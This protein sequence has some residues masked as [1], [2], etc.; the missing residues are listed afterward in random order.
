MK[1]SDNLENYDIPKGFHLSV[2]QEEELARIVKEIIPELDKRKTSKVETRK[3]FKQHLRY[4]SNTKDDNVAKGKEGDRFEEGESYSPL[5]GEYTWDSR[6]LHPV[7]IQVLLPEEVKYGYICNLLHQDM[8]SRGEIEARFWTFISDAMVQFAQ[9]FDIEEVKKTARTITDVPERILYLNRVKADYDMYEHMSKEQMEWVY[10]PFGDKLD[11]LLKEARAAYG[12][13][14]D[15]NAKEKEDKIVAIVDTSKDELKLTPGS[16][17]YHEDVIIN[18]LISQFNVSHHRVTEKIDLETLEKVRSIF[19]NEFNCFLNDLSV[20]GRQ[21]TAELLSY[22]DRWEDDLKRCVDYAYYHCPEY[23]YDQFIEVNGE[24]RKESF[25][26]DNLLFAKMAVQELR[27][28]TYGFKANLL[29]NN[30]ETTEILYPVWN[31]GYKKV[32]KE[33]ERLEKSFGEIEHRLQLTDYSKNIELFY[34]KLIPYIKSVITESLQKGDFDDIKEMTADTCGRLENGLR[35]MLKEYI[36]LFSSRE[37]APMLPQF[38][39]K[40]WITITQYCVLDAFFGVERVIFSS[41]PLIQMCNPKVLVDFQFEEMER[42]FTTL[43]EEYVSKTD[44][45]QY[46]EFKNDLSAINT[47]AKD[48]SVPSF[49]IDWVGDNFFTYDDWQ[50]ALGIEESDEETEARIQAAIEA[51]EKKQHEAFLE[52]QK[53]LH[54]QVPPSLSSNTVIVAPTEEEGPSEPEN[55]IT[56]SVTPVN[57]SPAYKS[58]HLVF[59]DSVN[60]EEK[61]IIYKYMHD[62]V[63]YAPGVGEFLY[64]KALIDEYYIKYPSFPQFAAEFPKYA[65][66]D[67]NF[68]AYFGSTGIMKDEL[69][70]IHQRKVDTYIKEIKRLLAKAKK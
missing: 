28:V 15:T 16:Y 23:E 58:C 8:E 64:I 31:G 48:Y 38:E 50:K 47:D 7:L 9:K 51:L 17:S 11:A 3:Y 33:R 52:L 29:L 55:S 1:V 49:K 21:D 69:K 18:D 24:E 34:K 25:R 30:R 45:P 14:K 68:S 6:I 19:E 40:A 39:V 53:V 35:T 44:D 61:P 37:E 67:S 26:V 27:L 22:I 62:H 4:S 66:K 10:Y 32:L 43:W 56:Q 36:S 70:P 60:E 54:G 59:Y 12:I 65:D 13:W 57:E 5:E 46:D 41:D 63:G 42:F 2:E 20:H